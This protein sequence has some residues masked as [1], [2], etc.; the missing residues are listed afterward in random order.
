[1]VPPRA[2]TSK[3]FAPR[4]PLP[5]PA[6]EVQEVKKVQEVLFSTSCTFF[7]SLYLLSARVAKSTPDP[8]LN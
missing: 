7:T 1:M 5:G 6:R 8:R 2:K 3:R 4:A